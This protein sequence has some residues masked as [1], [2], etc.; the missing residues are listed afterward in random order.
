MKA[1]SHANEQYY[2]IMHALKKNS[3]TSMARTP[4]EPWKLVRDRGIVRANHST[5]S[6]DTIGIS[7][8]F[9]LHENILRVL[10][11]IASLRSF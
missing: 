6:G 2:T 10:I 1:V 9:L 4:L 7:F 3:R 8:D 11:R 5:R